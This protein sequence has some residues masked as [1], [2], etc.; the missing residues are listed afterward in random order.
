MDKCDQKSRLETHK[1]FCICEKH[2]QPDDNVCSTKNLADLYDPKTSK[3]LK[4]KE[5]S[6]KASH[7]KTHF[8]QSSVSMLSKKPCNEKQTDITD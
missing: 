8:R 3:D 1:T 7:K 2:F 4:E 6:K 5:N